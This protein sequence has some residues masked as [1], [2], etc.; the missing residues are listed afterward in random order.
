MS[1]NWDKY[2]RNGMNAACT[3]DLC[4][5]FDDLYPNAPTTK[6]TVAHAR[7]LECERLHEIGSRQVAASILSGVA[8]TLGLDAVRPSSTTTRV[9]R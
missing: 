7:L 3:I 4:K 1:V 8:F 2:R 6:R 9:G 5:A